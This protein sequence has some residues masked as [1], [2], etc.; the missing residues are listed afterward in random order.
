MSAHLST[1]VN[2][3]QP[4][5]VDMQDKC[6]RTLNRCDADSVNELRLREYATASEFAILRPELL[7]W[8]EHDDDGVVVGVWSN[9]ELLSTLRGLVV[10]D[11]RG[12]ED[13]FECTVDLPKDM[14]PALLLGRGAT[15]ARYRRMGLNALLR[16]Y[17]LRAAIHTSDERTKVQVK[18]S[19]ALPYEGAPRVRLM[20]QLGYEL[21]RPASNWDSELRVIRPAFL[22]V[23]PAER[24]EAAERYLFSL[25]SGNLEQY[26]W[27]GSPLRLPAAVHFRTATSTP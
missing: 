21:S 10:S 19:L 16:F 5:E 17:L 26:P 22:A 14:F 27:C 9:G 23:L 24:F 4:A 7:L 2:R 25:V 20:Q 12:A 13:I 3:G 6:V 18:A 1:M 11:R 8:S 15:S